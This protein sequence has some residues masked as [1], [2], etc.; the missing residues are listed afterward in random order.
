MTIQIFYIKIDLLKLKTFTGDRL[1]YTIKDVAREA[2]VSIA[3]VSR[4]LNNKDW[5]KDETRNKIL[6]IVEKM[7]YVTNFSAKTLR[8]NRSNSIG[9]I[10]P[11]VSVP[12]YAQI[13]K[14]IENK[15]KEM[16]LRLIVC[17]A[18]NTIEKEL[19][20]ARFLYD[21][22]IDGLILIIPQ[23]SNDEIIKMKVDKR[24]VVIFGRNMQEYDIPS[25]TVDN[26]L[27][28]Y[29]AVKHLY[30]HGL[31]KIAFI[32]GINNENLDYRKERIEGYKQALKDCNLEFRS[33]YVENALYQ[34]EA[35]SSAFIHLMKLPDPPNA[36]FC[37]NDEMALGTLKTAK[38]L[39]IQIPGQVAVIGFDNIP[40]CQYTSPALTTMNQ[41]TYTIGNLC[42]E[43]LI[44]C[45]NNQDDNVYYTNLVIRPDLVIRESCGC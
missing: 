3:T 23:M 32:G 38:K 43:K 16:N 17:D 44:Y 22:S 35:A 26:K 29:N 41:P 30:S 42:C 45:L 21:H 31:N 14:G 28:S 20:F 8:N 25:I 10:V 39:G 11:E 1:A 19:D 12:F 2:G 40:V 6:A 27:G 36:V 34:E 33:E 5:V 15:A 4:V 18:D 37:G 24:P 13:I 9:V 7:N